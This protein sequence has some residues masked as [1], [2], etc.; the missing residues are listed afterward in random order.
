MC[1]NFQELL[2]SNILQTPSSRDRRQ[3][4]RLVCN[5]H[6]RKNQKLKGTVASQEK[7]KA[8]RNCRHMNL[9]TIE[10]ALCHMTCT[11]NK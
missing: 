5:T 6:P 8:E 9:Q 10:H 7:S 4:V 3:E 11:G 2:L 1:C